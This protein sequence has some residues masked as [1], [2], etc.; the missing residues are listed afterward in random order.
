[1]PPPPSRL[2]NAAAEL[3][4]VLRLYHCRPGSDVGAASWEIPCRSKDDARSYEEWFATVGRTTTAFDR[5]WK[6][7]QFGALLGPPTDKTLGRFMKT[8]PRLRELAVRFRS[9]ERLLMEHHAK[10]AIDHTR[11]IWL[12]LLQQ[13]WLHKA[14]MQPVFR[15]RMSIRGT[16]LS[17]DPKSPHA[18]TDFNLT[19][20]LS[21][22]DEGL[23]NDL[24]DAVRQEACDTGPADG[25][26]DSESDGEGSPWIEQARIDELIRFAN[27]EMKGMQQKLVLHL[28]N[29]GGAS[30]LDA[31]KKHLGWPKGTPGDGN[32]ES[33]QREVNKK[34]KRQRL[35]VKRVNNY[36]QLVP[37]KSG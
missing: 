25:T 17:F 37:Y 29:S 6:Y 24:L 4:R 12:R 34:L 9:F 10:T 7:G 36:A 20:Q 18:R 14:A 33:C 27:D 21:E 35:K 8:V 32:F 15:D 28:I 13:P 1:M 22:L 30:A 16:K 2:G 31:V 26:I 3:N 11:E 23:L 19:I 5:Q